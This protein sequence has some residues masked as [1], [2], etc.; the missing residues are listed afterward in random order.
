MASTMQAYLGM[1]QTSPQTPQPAQPQPTQP[2]FQTQ[3]Q[4][5]L[6]GVCVWEGGGQGEGGKEGGGGGGCRRNDLMVYM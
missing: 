4:P 2:L 6:T 5:Q 1:Q 3:P